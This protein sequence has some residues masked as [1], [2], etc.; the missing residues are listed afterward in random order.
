MRLAARLRALAA[1][2][3]AAPIAAATLARLAAALAARAAATPIGSAT[4][5]H[6]VRRRIHHLGDLGRH[7]RVL[8]P[9]RV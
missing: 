8:R 5:A 3:A 2:H 6:L 1:T 4:A 9:A 7:A